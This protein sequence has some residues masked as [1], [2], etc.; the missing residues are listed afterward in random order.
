MNITCI[1]PAESAKIIIEIKSS[2]Y[3]CS[4]II[5]VVDLSTA[6]LMGHMF[7]YI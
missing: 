5:Y 6:V 2:L 3:D 1:T 7:L 4:H